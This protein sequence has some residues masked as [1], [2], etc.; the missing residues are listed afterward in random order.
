VSLTISFL[1]AGALEWTVTRPTPSLVGAEHS[2]TTSPARS[3]PADGHSR[4]AVPAPG[5]PVPSAAPAVGRGGRASAH[6]TAA[7]PDAK[8]PAVGRA[9]RLPPGAIPIG[10]VPADRPIDIRFLLAPRDPAGLARLAGAVSDPSS[11]QYRHYLAKGEF[12]RRFAPAPGG[13]AAVRSAMSHWGL[14]PGPDYDGGLIVGA[15]GPARQVAR[16]LDTSLLEYRLPGGRVAFANSTAPRVPSSLA[17][18]ITGVDGLSNLYLARSAAVAPAAPTA[19]AAVGAQSTQRPDIGNPTGCSAANATASGTNSYTAPT[20]ASTYGLS[21]AYANN[22]YGSGETVALLELEPYSLSDIT[23]YEECFTLPSGVSY[24]TLHNV[25]V[26]GG[27]GVGTGGGEAALDIE[28]VAALAPAANLAVYEAPNGDQLD[29]YAQWASD[30]QAQVMS[31]SWGL[32]EPESDPTASAAENTV[33]EQAALQGQTIMAASGDD[34]SEAC[35]SPSTALSVDDPASQPFVT[36]VGGTDLVSSSAPATETVWNERAIS[37][38]AGGGGVSV[39]WAKP[40]WQS[41]TGSA[42]A[43]GHCDISPTSATTSASCRQVPDVSAAADPQ[44]GYIVYFNGSW[45]PIG[46]TSAAAPLWGALSA[47]ANRRCSAPLGFLNPRLYA[48]VAGPNFYDVTSGNNDYT[49]TNGGKY[50]AGIGWDNAS[51]WGAPDGVNLLGALCPSSVTNPTV[52]LSTNTAGS[53]G[54]IATTTFITSSGGALVAGSTITL[55]GPSGTSF[56]SSA[57]DY[58]VTGSTVSGV[59]SSGSGVT[60][61]LSASSIG[62]SAA[63]TVTVS[64][65]TNPT[66]TG[67]VTLTAATSADTVVATSSSYP[68]VAGP[69]SPSVSTAVASPTTVAADGTSQSVITVTDTDA[70]SNPVAGDTVTLSQGAGHSAITPASTTTS[71]TGV[72]TFIVKDATAEVV[73]YAA[74][75]ITQGVTLNEEPVV[76]FVIRKVSGVTV[77]PASPSTS[78]IAGAPSN[79]AIGFTTSALGALSSGATMTLAGP[80]GTSFP[81]SAADYTVTGSTVSGV[82]SSGPG[83]TIALSASSI[84][85]TSSVTVTVSGV[86]NPTVAG[87][88]SMGVSTSADTVVATSSSYPIAVGPPSPSVSTLTLAP[89]SVP[90]DGISSAT[91]TATMRNAFGQPVA[92]DTVTLHDGTAHAVV[93]PTTAITSASGTTTFTVTDTT[94]ETVTLAAFDVTAGVTLHPTVSVTFS[95]VAAPPTHPPAPASGTPQGYWLVANDGGIFSFGAAGFFGS[96]GSMH[97]NAPI[98][99]MSATPDGKGYW[100]VATDGGIFSFGAAGFFGSTGSLHLNKPIVA[101]SA[102]PDGKGYWLVA[103][104]GGI[105]SFGDAGFFGSTGALTLNKPIAGMAATPDGNGYWLVATDG[106]IF[107]FGDAGFFGSTGALPLNKPIAGMAATPDGKGY[108]LVAT[109]GGIFSFGDAGFFGSTGAMH[110]NAP[111]VGMG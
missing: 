34:G 27:P 14:S 3:R 60:I 7:A 58:T 2:T 94:A 87:S 81:S 11:P 16:V 13:V 25:N 79:Y 74:K 1:A 31:T 49:G 105:F 86:T 15:E 95:A 69:P 101:M 84:G 77:T 48:L 45:E 28:T 9:P 103:S 55:A 22:D 78:F 76:S 20:L 26:D 10:P 19:H 109:D 29:D 54:V 46:G 44:H 75:D 59:T 64:G 53:A 88:V 57:A 96:T 35:G 82:T 83:V 70:F 102:T 39:Q 40:T 110:L 111:I 21:T 104:D 43:G 62:G 98:V 33:F 100:L 8:S 4:T 108:R 91:V 72:A 17:A 67:A 30:D 38:G 56:P 107:S 106:G 68:I 23:T 80:S 99:A 18:V 52:T 50:A 89:T 73:T 42:P 65:V 61:A 41:V 93:A 66:A 12:A 5:D 85:A 47:L 24:G 6:L 71:G 63:V 32:C 37:N 90:A 36:G 92:G 97:L 51:G